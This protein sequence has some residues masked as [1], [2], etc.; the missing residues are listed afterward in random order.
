MPPPV[1]GGQLFWQS[2]SV[3]Q[4]MTHMPP[5]TPPLEPLD[6][7][8]LDPLLEPLLE[9]LE[10]LEAPELLPLELPEPELLTVPELLPLPLDEEEPASP[11][12]S[13]PPVESPDP[14]AAITATENT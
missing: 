13:N 14:H 1:T 6:D 2:E 8:L 11:E 7:P 3:W 4:V 5:S 12:V 10:L 9:P